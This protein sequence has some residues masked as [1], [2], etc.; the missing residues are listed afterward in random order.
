MESI[1]IRVEILL[2]STTVN[3]NILSYILHD[4][5]QSRMVLRMG[6]DTWCVPDDMH[7]G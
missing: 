7:C 3:R 4:N 5:L 6:K 2:F 1:V